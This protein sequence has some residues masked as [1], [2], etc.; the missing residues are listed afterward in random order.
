MGVANMASPTL[1]EH[2]AFCTAVIKEVDT[3]TSWTTISRT[4]FKRIV[5]HK[6]V[7]RNQRI[8]WVPSFANQFDPSPTTSRTLAPPTNSLQAQKPH[9]ESS[10]YV[11]D[12]IHQPERLA[13]GDLACRCSG[14]SYA[15][16]DADWCILG[17]HRSS[18]RHYVMVRVRLSIMESY[19]HKQNHSLIPITT[20]YRRSKCDGLMVC[21]T[22]LKSKKRW[23]L[24][25]QNDLS[26]P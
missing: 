21:D 20:R 7:L 18:R 4:W 25:Y 5:A 14:D 3:P 10:E 24:K 8:W 11:I 12:Y 22:K 19:L 26:F 9:L 17:L 6:Y 15:L 1:G 13:N 23:L 2:R 16:N